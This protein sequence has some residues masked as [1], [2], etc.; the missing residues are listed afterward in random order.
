VVLL[1]QRSSPELLGSCCLEVHF[2]VRHRCLISAT[3][4]RG[5]LYLL[6]RLPYN[7]RVS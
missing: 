6:D 5:S 2:V 7:L 4:E 1:A 3:V